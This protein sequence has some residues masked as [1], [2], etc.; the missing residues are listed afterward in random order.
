MGSR[1]EMI[2]TSRRVASALVVPFLLAA[3]SPSDSTPT[4]TT[5]TTTTSTTIAPTT[6]AAEPTTTTTEPPIVLISVSGIEDGELT[7]AVGLGLSTIRDP[8]VAGAVADG[9]VTHHEGAAS[10]LADRYTAEATVAELA[11]GSR[12][13]VATL[14][15][16]DLLLLS[17]EGSGW[18][19]VGA[20]LGSIGAD[21]YF[22][23]SPRRVLVLG[24]DARPG[25]DASVHRMDSIHILT[26]VPSERAG[27]ILGYPRDSWID[28]EY[29]SMRMNALTSS[30]RGPDALF[31]FFTDTWEV[32]LEG[33]ILTGFA[34]F[35][36]LVGAAFGRLRLTIPIPIPTQEWFDG[37]SSGEQTLN[38]TRL[39]DF[40]RTRKLIPGGD[41][42]RSYHHGIVMLAALAT[43]QE[44]SIHDLP[45]LLAILSRFTETNLTA[46]DL[47]QL[48]AAAFELDRGAITN[49]V[50]PGSL[51]RAGGGASVV[52]L[53]P[54]FELIVADVID[55]GLR[56]DSAG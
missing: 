1:I 41:F 36:D 10:G 40:A 8:R 18:A 39:L 31:E 23:E 28:S 5:S 45:P 32:P 29:G 17:D 3:C 12:V 9:V 33:Y 47:L 22:G 24:S 14:D 13:A 42:T 21:P 55:D 19:T 30:G 34:G 15:G 46:T 16:G 38:P 11:D 35:E 50:L 56:N 2:T 48:G 44:G 43:I 6:T 25:G 7:A 26:S 4:S 27:S 52:F 37:F 53:D 51:G 54:G 49:E 20:H